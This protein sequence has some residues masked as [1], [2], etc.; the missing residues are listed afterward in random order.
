MTTTLDATL[1]APTAPERYA[2]PAARGKAGRGLTGWVVAF[3]LFDAGIK[4]ALA[5]PAVESTAQLGFSRGAVLWIG[6]VELACLALYLIPRTALLGAVLFTGYLGGAIATHA[7]LGNPLFTH[8]LFP[9]YVAAMLWEASTSAT[10]AC[11][12]CSRRRAE[13]RPER[14]HGSASPRACRA[15]R[16]PPPR[17]SPPGARRHRHREASLGYRRSPSQR[18]ASR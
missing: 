4:L 3:L 16:A 1:D 9:V 2:T 12:R 14:G 6:L 15:P 5:T 17:C 11:A 18:R 7:R 13:L 8:V 10:L